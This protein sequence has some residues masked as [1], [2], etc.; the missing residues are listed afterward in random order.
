MARAG[1]RFAELHLEKLVGRQTL[2]VSVPRDL[3]VEHFNVLGESILEIIKNHTGCACL[4][5][6]IDVVL[7]EQFQEA[8]RVEFN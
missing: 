8:V 7:Q 4:S 2:T 6:V 5:G 1:E 3:E